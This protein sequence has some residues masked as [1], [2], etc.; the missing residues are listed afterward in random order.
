MEIIPPVSQELARRG[1]THRLFR[2]QHPIHSLAEAAAERGQRPEQVVRSLLFRLAE[3]DYR[4]VLVA[5]ER[6]VD[7]KALRRLLGVR[8]VTMA[9]PE[10]VL[11]VTG[12]PIGAVGPLGLKQPVPILVDESVL[13]EE[14]ISLGS[15]VRG[16]A[17]IL[18]PT[19]LLSALGE[20]EMVQV[21]AAE[22]QR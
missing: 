1:I 17:V 22:R 20:V 5:G 16:V 12:H 18:R 3:G 13:A 6:Q 14:E 2:H 4:L 15:G 8:R 19:D 10:E 11:A 9:S 7:W 21:S